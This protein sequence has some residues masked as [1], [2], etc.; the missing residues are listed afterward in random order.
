MV[1]ALEIE[2][3]LTKTRSRSLS[4]VAPFGGNL[5]GV[6]AASIAYF[7]KEPKR[8]SLA[9]AALL[10]ALPQSPNQEA[11]SHPGCRARAEGPGARPHGRGCSASVETPFRPGPFRC[12]GYANRCRSWRRI[13]PIRPR[14]VK[15]RR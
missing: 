11:G 3:Q 1:R 12:R 10:V 13:R 6:R 15:D 14:T 5:E 9:E 8:L 4:G 7:G 2:Q